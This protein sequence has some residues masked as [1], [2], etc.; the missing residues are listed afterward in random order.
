VQLAKAKGIRV[1]GSGRSKVEP[2]VLDLGADEFVDVEHGDWAANMVQVDVVL[3]T[4]GGAVLASSVDVVKPGGALVSV[5]EPP[6]TDRD[7]VRTIFF[8]RNPN[9]PQLSEIARLVEA[10]NVRPQVGAVFPLAKARDAFAAKSGGGIPGRVV[11]Q[12]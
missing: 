8:V 11:L 9:G 2:L 7:D 1:I 4:I 10:G 5:A 3:D 6:T 12:P